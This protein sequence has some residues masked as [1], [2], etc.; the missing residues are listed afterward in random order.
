MREP[1]TLRRR[2]DWPEVLATE[3]DAR[4]AA[5]FVWGLNDCCTLACDMVLALTGV[6]PIAEFRGSYNNEAGA[7]A[8][9]IHEGGLAALAERVAAAAGLGACH[10]GFAQRGDVALVEHGNTLAMGVIAGDSVAVP[11]PDGL[12]FLPLSVVLRAWSV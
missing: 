5:S 7:E 8:I 3:L 4:A 12:H 6:D 11:G 1:S 9:L 10:P 2:Q